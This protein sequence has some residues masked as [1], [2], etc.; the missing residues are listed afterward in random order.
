MEKQKLLVIDLDGTICEQTYNNSY[1][2]AKPHEDVIEKLRTLYNKGWN[3]TIHTAR[4]MRTCSGDVEEV[5]RRYRLMTETWLIKHDVPFHRLV[6]G[7]PP[8]DYYVDDRGMSPN[9][10]VDDL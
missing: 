9:E 4:G 6:F 3:I 1:E 5:E 2:F 10:F 8:G 7:K